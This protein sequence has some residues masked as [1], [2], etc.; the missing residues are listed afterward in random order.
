MLV[1]CSGKAGHGLESGLGVPGLD[2]IPSNEM[3]VNK[4]SSTAVCNS[5]ADPEGDPS[6]TTN[7]SP[8]ASKE[9]K[10]TKCKWGMKKHQHKQV[11]FAQAQPE[12]TK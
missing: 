8:N 11:L 10:A 6:G 3:V 9:S 12:V 1:K 5:N 4:P 7:W 2:I